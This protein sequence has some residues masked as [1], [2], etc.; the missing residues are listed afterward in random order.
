M[1]EKTG[2]ANDDKDKKE[3][4]IKENLDIKKENEKLQKYIITSEFR[5]AFAMKVNFENKKLKEE[6]SKYKKEIEQLK[7]NGK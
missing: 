3:N 2:G 1:E 6:I 4:L 7:K 5:N